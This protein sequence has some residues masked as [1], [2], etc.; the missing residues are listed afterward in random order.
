MLDLTER[1]RKE[2]MVLKMFMM[3]GA[4]IISLW[5]PFQTNQS[6]LFF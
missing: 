5:N 1:K 3:S 6:R 4:G 2:K